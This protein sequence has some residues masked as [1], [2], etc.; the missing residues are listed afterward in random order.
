MANALITGVS[1]FVGHHLVSALHSEGHCV[2]GID[3]T[4]PRPDHP[5]SEI[6]VAV[7]ELRDSGTV[8]R[9]LAEAHI[10]WIF[11]LAGSSGTSAEME[12]YENNVF[13]SV[14]L[15]EA[16]Q[17]SRR[18]L[19]IVIVASSAIYGESSNAEPLN[20]FALLQPLSPYGVSKATVDLLGF[21]FC[22]RTGI[23]V[24]RARPFNIVGPAQSPAFFCSAV[25]QQVA[26]A[27]RGQIEP[28]IHVRGVDT[29]RD[30]VDV[31]DV[32]DAL[33][34][35]AKSGTSGEA[36]NV[37]SGVATPLHSVV[38]HMLNCAKVRM[39]VVAD[40]PQPAGYPDVQTQR[41]C[42]GKLQTASGW[43]PQISLRQSLDD[44]LNYW[45]EREQ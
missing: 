20:E 35:I 11:H 37:C 24:L 18:P 43:S 6:R 32:A 34:S 38:E 2:T 12:L 39:S 5:A 30:F 1:G 14:A 7:G 27:E 21:Q 41:G 36:Y 17:V 45:R 4:L 23:P 44:T 29:E 40:V 8:A 9:L 22:R 19:R 25:A 13:G 33:V 10:D 15:L 3:R 42:Y 16:A 26:L 28:V 31:R